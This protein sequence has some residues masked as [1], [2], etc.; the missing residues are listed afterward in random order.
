MGAFNRARH[1]RVKLSLVGAALI[2]A[3]PALAMGQTL[4]WGGW[5]WW[6]LESWVR[7]IGDIMDGKSDGTGIIERGWGHLW[8][9]V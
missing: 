4:T 2:R 8:L 6:I 3:R 5:G 1:A 7:E 9:G